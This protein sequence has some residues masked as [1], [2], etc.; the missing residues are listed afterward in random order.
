MQTKINVFF[1]HTEYHLMLSVHIALSHFSE[2]FFQ[3]K[4]YFTK[5]PQRFNSLMD[6]NLRKNIEIIGL[7]EYT[8]HVV[9]Q[10]G[11]IVCDSFFFF[12]ENSIFNRYVAHL[13][14]GRGGKIALVQD[15][16]K[17]YA[18]FNKSHAFLSM[19]K[20]T[21][22]DYRKLIKNGLSLNALYISDYYHYGK[23]RFIDE[24][25][26][27]DPDMF[28]RQKNKTHA[29]IV[30]IRAFTEESFIGISKLF[31]FSTEEFLVRKNCIF[32][33][34]QPF[35]EQGLI[36]IEIEFLSKLQ[37]K[38]NKVLYI[39]LHPLTQQSTIKRYQEIEGVFCIQSTIPA[40]LFIQA[41]SYSIILSGWSAGLALDNI[42]CS[43]YYN[44]PIYLNK[45][46]KILDQLVIKPMK[47][48]QVVDRIETIEFPN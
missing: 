18:V 42:S 5:S 36:D 43:F 9:A 33:L 11:D 25:W 7:G 32:Y 13:L 14:K 40:E 4:I 19:I 15:G 31:C 34:N 10:M 27:S 48:I 38:F 39:K 20:D 17:P 21:I 1:A 45:G 12:Q 6:Y 44:F 26:L 8:K 2:S 16:I 35:R 24:L 46:S 29:E 30:K 23:T 22:S 47:H 41:L 3:N 37:K 28:D